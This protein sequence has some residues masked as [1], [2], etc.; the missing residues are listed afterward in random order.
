MPDAML[1][2]GCQPRQQ[3][4]PLLLQ[5]GWSGLLITPVMAI[6]TIVGLRGPALVS[7]VAL[8]HDRMRAGLAPP[9][10]RLLQL[11]VLALLHSCCW[12]M[13]SKNQAAMRGVLGG[14]SALRS[15]ALRAPAFH[16]RRVLT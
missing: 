3:V 6:W 11:L 13:L 8:A 5:L 12:M 1:L 15:D 2:D 16:R 14:L 10:A 7:R 4:L 9:R